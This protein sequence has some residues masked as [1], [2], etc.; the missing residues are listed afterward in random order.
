LIFVVALAVLLIASDWFV[1]SSEKIGLSLGISPFIIGV[2]IVAF[3]TSLPELATSIISVNEGMSEIVIA[4]VVGSNVTN[5][6]LVLGM[7]AVVAGDI[8]MDFDVMDI[9]M[10][11]LFGSAFLLYFALADLHFSNFEAILFLGGLMAFLLNSV[12]G[13][14]NEVLDRPKSSYKDYLK[15][16]IAA[17]LVYFGAEYV[18]Y[19]VEHCSN[20]LGINK[21]FIAITVIALGTSLPE[22]VVSITAAKKGKTGLAVGNVLGSNMFNTFGVM[23]IPGLMTHLVIPEHMLTLSIPF[24]IAVTILFGMIS[25]SKRISFWE[26]SMMVAFYVFFIGTTLE[27]IM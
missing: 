10:P 25:L 4:N 18:I 16:I 27:T 3:G 1:D 9:D 22:L 14:K 12:S 23:G 8:K 19:A 2:T 13:K 7:T 24:M 5:I 6:L 21:D 20:D 17:V 26:G 15:M 11:L